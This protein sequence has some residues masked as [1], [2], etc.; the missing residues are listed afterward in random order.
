MKEQHVQT[1]GGQPTLGVSED[2]G[3]IIALGSGVDANDVALIHHFVVAS[4]AVGN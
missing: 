4:V 2:L 3:A 1:Y